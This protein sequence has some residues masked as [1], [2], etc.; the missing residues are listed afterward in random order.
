MPSDSAPTKNFRRAGPGSWIVPISLL[1]LCLVTATAFF[2][3]TSPRVPTTSAADLVVP[4]PTP[5]GVLR[6]PLVTTILTLDPARAELTSEILLIQQ[7]Y[8]GLTALDEHLNVVPA[9]ARYWDISHDGQTYTFEL[10][11]DAVFHNGRPVTAEDCVFSFERLLTTGLN[12]NNYHYFSRIEG[13]QEFREG[14]SKHVSGLR[15][16]DEKTFQ[17]RFTSP[18]VPALS[19]LSMYCSKILPK[20]EL[21]EQGEDFFKKPMGTGPFQFSRW[22][23][24][25]EDPSVPEA[26][27]IPQSLRLEANASYFGRG[28]YLDAVVF[29][30]LRDVKGT[31]REIPAIERFDFLPEMTKD[32]T[33]PPG[34]T[35]GGIMKELSIRYLVLPA[36]VPPFDDARVRRALHL[37]LDKRR[38]LNAMPYTK[39]VHIANTIVPPGIPG[40]L[41]TEVS[42][43]QNLLRAKELLAEA[44]HEM[45]KG[46]PPLEIPIYRGWDQGEEQRALF[47]E[48][49]SGI[50]VKVK[51]V[52]TKRWALIEES[53]M[54]GRPL[55]YDSGW[56]ADFPDPDNFLRPLFHST[57]PVNLS[58]YKNPEV[59]ALLDE[60]WSETSYSARNKLYHKIEAIL[61]QDSP[62]IPLYYDNL[63]YLV[64]SEVEGFSISPMGSAYLQL[65]QVWLREDQTEAAVDF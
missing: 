30:S 44:G 25:D 36:D 32:F 17:I 28:P 55:I 54:T 10:R 18:F 13:A 1:V 8:D 34:W 7:I 15:A 16:L 14:L 42:H 21:R 40:F 33:V 51:V 35:S 22:I 37:A 4:Q 58:G 12:M 5:G 50:G 49:L 27:G 56:I 31:K 53:P 23:G 19:V 62:V 39:G 41:S 57:S 43:R 60:A 61:L 47:K 59:D 20:A 46:L 63:A 45:G 26:Y 65:N 64:R 38:Y 24:R 11:H 48:C 6:I 29:R 52:K 9:L 2:F 3:A